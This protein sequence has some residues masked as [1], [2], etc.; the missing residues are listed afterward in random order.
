VRPPLDVVRTFVETPFRSGVA[1]GLGLTLAAVLLAGDLGAFAA[2]PTLVGL[3]LV[4]SYAV[5]TALAWARWLS[6]G[7]ASTGTDRARDRGRE[8]SRPRHARRSAR[9]GDDPAVGERRETLDRL[10]ERY[11][12]G[13]L[14]EATFERKLEALL[15]TETPEAARRHV[16]R[17]RRSGEASATEPESERASDADPDPDPE[18]R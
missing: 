6:D 12:E 16:A 13:E 8:R 11:A 2:A 15:G 1:V 9:V 14:D 5:D 18:R 10:R 4:A 3:G 7:S 17:T